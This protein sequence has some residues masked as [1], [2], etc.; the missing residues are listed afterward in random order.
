M[1]S[2]IWSC[3]SASD[4]QDLSINALY[5]NPVVDAPSHHKYDAACWHHV[6]PHFGPDPAG[7]RALMAQ[8]QPD[9]PVTWQ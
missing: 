2:G 5:L 4:L 6:D 7:D 3:P 1:R 8:E 9:G